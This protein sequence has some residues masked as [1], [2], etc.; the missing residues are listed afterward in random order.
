MATVADPKSY[1]NYDS[2]IEEE[3]GVE[4]CAYCGLPADTVDHVIPRSLR[5]MLVDVGGWRDRWGRVTDTVPAC[6]EC[7]SLVGSMVFNTMREKR[8]YI[9]ERMRVKYKSV[10]RTPNWDQDELDELSPIMRE[11]VVASMELAH[12]IRERLRWR[13]SIIRENFGTATEPIV[14]DAV[15]YPE[16]DEA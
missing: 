5:Y 14:D 1:F 15:A 13:G 7:N 8:N 6:H 10:L 12:L 11:Y 16:R 9:H 4:P 3:D 2:P